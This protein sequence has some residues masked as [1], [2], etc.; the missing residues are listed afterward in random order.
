MEDNFKCHLS[1]GSCILIIDVGDDYHDHE[2]NLL[3][4]VQ[5]PVVY[6]ALSTPSLPVT[7]TWAAGF[8]FPLHETR[9]LWKMDARGRPGCLFLNVFTYILCYISY[10]LEVKIL[11]K[12]LKDQWVAHIKGIGALYWDAKLPAT[13]S[14]YTPHCGLHFSRTQ[15]YQDGTGNHW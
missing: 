12:K 1:Q 15:E 5:V 8:S 6:Q 4:F 2:D 11:E 3:T 13:L 9:V 7:G 14:F 10:V